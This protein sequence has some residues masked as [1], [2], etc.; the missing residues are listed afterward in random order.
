MILKG[1]D[2]VGTAVFL[3]MLVPDLFY[4]TGKKHEKT[5]E[6]VKWDKKNTGAIGKFAV[7]F[8]PFLV[9]QGCYRQ[10]STL[11]SLSSWHFESVKNP[12]KKDWCNGRMPLRINNRR[13][14]G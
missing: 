14:P 8:F 7:V 3:L 9:L 10:Y 4:L 6:E 12:S 2:F 13:N 11:P 1:E 5:G